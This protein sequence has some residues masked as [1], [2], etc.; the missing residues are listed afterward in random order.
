MDTGDKCYE[1]RRVQ[2]QGA[3]IDGQELWERVPTV[4]GKF[5]RWADVANRLLTGGKLV[6]CRTCGA[7]PGTTW[8]AGKTRDGFEGRGETKDYVC[9]VH[10]IRE[11]VGREKEED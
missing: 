6:A 1:I 9:G 7:R 4:N 5:D 11:T 3:W 10:A 2:R 8:I